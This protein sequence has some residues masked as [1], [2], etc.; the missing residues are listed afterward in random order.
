[1]Y[2]KKNLADVQR[3]HTSTCPHT[4]DTLS[5]EWQKT[6][7]R[8]FGG[9]SVIL[10]ELFLFMIFNIFNKYKYEKSDV[11]WYPYSLSQ[12]LV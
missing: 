6:D 5:N 8:L 1:M 12:Y 11:H 4:F 7:Y 2:C 10:W 3:T 9:G